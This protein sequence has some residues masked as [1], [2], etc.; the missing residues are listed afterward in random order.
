MKRRLLTIACVVV[1]AAGCA[2]VQILAPPL[3]AAAAFPADGADGGPSF[4]TT[5]PFHRSKT[6]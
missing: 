6:P 4:F 5:T 2:F 3:A 1:A